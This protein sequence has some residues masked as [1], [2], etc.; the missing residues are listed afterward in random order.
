MGLGTTLELG[1][2]ELE[3]SPRGSTLSP[4]THTQSAPNGGGK[5]CGGAQRTFLAHESQRSILSLQQ[6]ALNSDE[7]YFKSAR[8]D[9]KLDVVTPS[10]QPL[11]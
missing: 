8:Q 6:E 1:A 7:P 3:A 10:G 5:M 11:P 2:A 4:N 9:L